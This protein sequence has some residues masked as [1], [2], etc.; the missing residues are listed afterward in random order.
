[1]R[2]HHLATVSRDDCIV[3]AYWEVKHEMDY[4]IKQLD[5]LEC[6]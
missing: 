2:V 3:D 5:S 1:M 6:S 4:D